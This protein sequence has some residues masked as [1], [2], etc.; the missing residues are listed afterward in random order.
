[1]E[2][3]GSARARRGAHPLSLPPPPRYDVTRPKAARRLVHELALAGGSSVALVREG[4][5]GRRCPAS[6][7]RPARRAPPSFPGR[8]PLLHA[9]VVRVVRVRERA[10]SWRPPSFVLR[11]ASAGRRR[12]LPPP[13]A[14]ARVI[15]GS[16]CSTGGSAGWCVAGQGRVAGR[17]RGAGREGDRAAPSLLSLLPPPRAPH[18]SASASSTAAFRLFSFTP[19]AVR[20]MAPRR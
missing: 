3:R 16:R 18:G 9:A 17:G 8:R 12:R 4:R 7:P 13:P 1:M 5:E 20:T 19:V 10:V 11:A 14:P 6:L 15:R 2:G